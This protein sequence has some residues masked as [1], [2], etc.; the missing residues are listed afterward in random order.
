MRRFAG[1]L[2]DEYVRLLTSISAAAIAVLL[3]T[4]FITVLAARRDAALAARDAVSTRHLVAELRAFQRIGD[5]HHSQALAEIK[6]QD[7]QLTAEERQITRLLVDHS[8]DLHY[9]VHILHQLRD[10]ERA[11]LTA[12]SSMCAHS[13]GCH[14]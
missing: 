4:G 11:I 14:T 3:V 8:S 6:T 7:I 10:E 13:P 2:V 5:L 12:I 1:W 9:E